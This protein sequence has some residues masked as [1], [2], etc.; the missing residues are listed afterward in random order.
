MWIL[1]V[2]SSVR[3]RWIL[4]VGVVCFTGWGMYVGGEGSPPPATQSIPRGK[5][6]PLTGWGLVVKSTCPY[7]YY[8]VK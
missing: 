6:K 4:G 8:Y 3:C 2:K 5:P 7:N 1:A